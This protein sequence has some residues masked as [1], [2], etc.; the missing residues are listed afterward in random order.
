MSFGFVPFP[1][2]GRDLEKAQISFLSSSAR[3]KGFFLFFSYLN[4][5][6][7]E[8]QSLPSLGDLEELFQG[9]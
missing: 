8:D 2:L 1:L 4:V 7:R 5:V 6:R 9:R 3:D